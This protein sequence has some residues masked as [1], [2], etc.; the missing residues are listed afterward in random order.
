VALL[1]K[2]DEEV[3]GCCCSAAAGEGAAT[4]R[5]DCWVVAGEDGDG[6]SVVGCCD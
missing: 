4:G 2:G 5:K 3:A 1:V 6:G